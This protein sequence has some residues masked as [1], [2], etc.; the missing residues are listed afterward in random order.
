LANRNEKRKPLRIYLSE[1]KWND[2]KYSIR[3]GIIKKLVAA[4]QI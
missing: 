4:K 1:D 3:D 2:G